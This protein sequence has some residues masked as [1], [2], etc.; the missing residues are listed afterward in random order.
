MIP[1]VGKSG[2]FHDPDEI[3]GGGLRIVDQAHHGVADLTEVVRRDVGGHADRDPARPV[4]EEVGKQRRHHRRLAHTWD[5]REVRAEVDSI[6]L[7]VVDE[8]HRHR[9]HARF[10]VPVCGR[11]ITVDRS[12]VPLPVDERIPHHPRLGKADERVVDRR[13]TVRVVLA[14]N[15]TDDRGALLVASPGGHAGVEHRPEDAAL[16]RLQPVA[17][18]R[19]RAADDHAHRVVHVGRAHLRLEFD[20]MDLAGLEHRHYADQPPPGFSP[21]P[22]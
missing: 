5:V 3:L 22:R 21:R 20:G 13:V 15:L 18:V 16:R 8:A 9:R 17:N 7:D 19:Q 1:P 14:E 11:R 4:D 2:P 6:L 10:G 12:E